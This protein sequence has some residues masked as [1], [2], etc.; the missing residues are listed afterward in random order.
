MTPEDDNRDAAR[1]GQLERG[2]CR[3][4]TA[5]GNPGVVYDKDVATCDRIAGAHPAWVNA[6]GMDFRWHDGQPH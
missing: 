5:A 2:G 6:S 4:G 3:L 1:A